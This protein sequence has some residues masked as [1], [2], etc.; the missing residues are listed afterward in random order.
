MFEIKFSSF[1]LNVVP[2]VD[3]VAVICL[4]VIIVRGALFYI[5][6]SSLYSSTNNKCELVT[7]PS[8]WAML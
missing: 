7:H 2:D 6:Q 4:P 8:F 5:R 3:P 1:V